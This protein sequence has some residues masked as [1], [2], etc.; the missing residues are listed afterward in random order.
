MLAPFRRRRPQQDKLQPSA[1][2][3]PCEAVVML[4]GDELDEHQ[5]MEY[6]DMAPWA[7][8]A[9]C[10][11]KTQPGSIGTR[12][13]SWCLGALWNLWKPNQALL[14]TYIIHIYIYRLIISSF[15]LMLFV[16]EPALTLKPRFQTHCF[17]LAKR[18]TMLRHR[19]HFGSFPVAS[20]WL[21]LRWPHL[22]TSRR[23]RPKRNLG[24]SWIAWY[25]LVLQQPVRI[26]HDF[27]RH[28]ARIS[29]V[30]VEKQYI[31]PSSCQTITYR[32]K[33][34]NW[35]S[36]IQCTDMYRLYRSI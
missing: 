7:L 4:E 1:A 29:R 9:G 30:P 20:A 34:G 16:T 21:N 11:L 25:R 18:A 19:F 35:C 26:L 3:S 15:C 32:Q 27:T 2:I 8:G 23:S 14:Y 33:W 13:L 28:T 22:H 17:D 24:S 36:N 5:P 6:L 12:S 10:N 31:H